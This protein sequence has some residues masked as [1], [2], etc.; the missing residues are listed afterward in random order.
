MFT[1]TFYGFLRVGELVAN[2]KMDHRQ[3]LLVSNI[4]YIG[5]NNTL[6]CEVY[7]DCGV[8]NSLACVC[9]L[10]AV[11]CTFRTKRNK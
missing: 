8:V 7:L 11:L 6:E 3:A 2:S 9:V 1:I 4:R 10:H 5:S